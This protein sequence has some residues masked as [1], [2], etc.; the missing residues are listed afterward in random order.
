MANF[1][2]SHYLRSVIG[3]K[4]LILHTSLLLLAG[5]ARSESGLKSIHSSGESC[6]PIYVKWPRVKLGL[7]SAKGGPLDLHKCE[8]G[9]YLIFLAVG[10]QW[11]VGLVCT[12]NEDPEGGSSEHQCSAFNH[13]A[14]INS[15]GNG[16]SAL[17]LRGAMSIDCA[18]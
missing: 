17:S 5:L 15:Y 4:I 10:H 8:E 3:R 16:E 14:G 7:H 1:P 11:N 9:S 6:Q 2:L 13:K 18:I 12:K